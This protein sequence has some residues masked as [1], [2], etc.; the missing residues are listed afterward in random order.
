MRLT[1]LAVVTPL[2]LAGCV[3]RSDYDAKV[4]EAD[5]AR[6]QA[7]AAKQQ[8]AQLQQQLTT[9]DQQINDLKGALGIAQSQAMT[10]EQK[11]E[12][13]DAKRAV[14]EAQERAKLL[15]DLQTK[16][17][18]M[19]DAGHLKVTTR[20]GRIVL[21]L[22]NDV[23][24]DTG[25]ADVKP[26]GKDAIQEVAAALRGMATRRFQVAGH[27]DNEP[28]T[29]ETQKKFPTNWELSTARA[30]AVVKILTSD[31]V[32]PTVLSAAGYGPYD[33]V[34]S[35]GSPDG[36][37]KN[38]RIEITLVPNVSQLVAAADKGDKGKK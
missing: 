38:R 8:A 17:K 1:W 28:I 10:D 20:H 13:D 22:H 24:F 23:L 30:I 31:G 37:A 15:D 6:Q 3:T 35:N 19:I 14:Q 29:P 33:P 36:Q 25:Q 12:L 18:K 5:L 21:Q 2:L 26:A 11:T 7:D 16:L 9:N 4:R 32:E 34:A 27:T